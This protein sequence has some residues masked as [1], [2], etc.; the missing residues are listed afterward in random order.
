[1][2]ESREGVML[3]CGFVHKRTETMG[4]KINSSVFPRFFFIDRSSSTTEGFDTDLLTLTHANSSIYGELV[5]N[6]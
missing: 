4:K 2:P 1:M 6:S 3:Y 5:C